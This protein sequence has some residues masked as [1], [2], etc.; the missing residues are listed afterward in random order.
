LAEISRYVKDKYGPNYAP[1]TP[2]HYAKKVRGAQEAHEAIR[3]T[4][5]LREPSSVRGYLSREQA[6]LYDL[7]WRRMLASQMTDAIF[8]SAT[9]DVDAACAG[10][11]TVYEFRATGSVLRFPG[12]R[13]LYLESKD[14]SSAGDD[15]DVPQLPDLSEGDPLDERSLTPDQH[16]TQP[17]PR[18][19][20]ATLVK[21]LEEQGIGRPSTYAPTLATVMDRD[22]VRKDKG[23]FVPTKLG[24]AV[25]KLLTTHFPDIMDLGFTAR[26]EEQLDD[27]ASGECSWK[28]VIKEFY[29][30][31]T[32]AV[33]KA[34]AEAE[35]VPRDQIDEETDEVCEVCGR[36]MVIKTGRFGRFLSCSGF[37]ECKTSRPLLER[38]GVECPECGNDLVERQ[39]RAKGKRGGRSKF[40]GCSNYP[41]CTFAVNQRPIPQPCPEC[42][43]M[44]VASGRSNAKCTSC[45]FRGPV[46]ED[47]VVEM[48]S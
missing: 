30:P 27:I 42:S 31:F 29:G 20:E 4:S 15:D 35:R 12:F 39:S 43:K 48:A 13:R 34:L 24:T 6:R 25:S 2:R 45:D 3:P 26:V 36:P 7:I 38:V 33:Q 17:P 41:V 9:I 46:P 8:D 23:R 47:V 16:F 19:T 37:P 22:Y 32:E 40:Y 1:K 18:F 21:A 5:I 28:P 11:N 10:P 14:D 44:L